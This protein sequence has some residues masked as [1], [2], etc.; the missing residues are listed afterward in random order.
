MYRLGGAYLSNP[1]KSEVANNFKLAGGVGYRDKG[2]FIDLTYVYSHLKDVNY[3]YRLE[4]K[5]NESAMVS[6]TQGNILLT[7]G[8]KF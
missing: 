2:I 6:S 8:F 1:Y 7:I 3:P 5:S 4:D